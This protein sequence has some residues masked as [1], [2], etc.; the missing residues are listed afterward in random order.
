[1]VRKLL[2]S[3][4][5]IALSAAYVAWLASKRD[6]ALPDPSLLDPLP[7]AQT[8]RQDPAPQLPAPS[9]SSGTSTGLHDGTFTGYIVDAYYG[10]MQIQI[11]VNA[12]RVTAIDPVRYPLDREVSRRISYYIIPIL[13]TEVVR[14]QKT[15]VDMIT[16]ATLTVTAYRMSLTDA[17]RQAQQGG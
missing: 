5:V 17:L 1:M 14:E 7:P 11:T 4:S 13:E 6:H 3:V 9:Q 8:A 15:N 12:G 10:L 16:G 2:L